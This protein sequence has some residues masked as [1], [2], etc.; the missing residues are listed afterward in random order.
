ML[1]LV[2]MKNKWK[3]KGLPPS[4]LGDCDLERLLFLHRDMAA[5]YSF[6]VWHFLNLLYLNTIKTIV[7]RGK[8]AFWISFSEISTCKVL[9][10]W[11]KK[12]QFLILLINVTFHLA[13]SLHD[14]GSPSY[15]QWFVLN[16]LR[17]KNY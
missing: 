17:K 14:S 3:Y 11:R 6:I 15:G 10:F 7:C 12:F 9:L 4:L 5:F 16:F 2:K 13:I 1:P 8:N